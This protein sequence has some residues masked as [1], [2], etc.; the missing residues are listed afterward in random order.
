MDN[1][2]NAFWTVTDT[3]SLNLERYI[4]KQ[5]KVSIEK[6]ELMK[7]EPQVQKELSK[8]IKDQITSELV[9]SLSQGSWDATIKEILT[10]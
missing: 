2:K 1:R 6:K 7:L 4:R 9:Q 10:Q 8:I 5:I 3:D